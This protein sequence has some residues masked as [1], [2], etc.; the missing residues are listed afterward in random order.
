MDRWPV[1][2]TSPY[3]RRQVEHDADINKDLLIIDPVELLE[4]FS[5]HYMRD[6]GGVIFVSSNTKFE[7]SLP[8]HPL[9]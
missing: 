3:V 4:I 9:L 6:S 7:F 1:I 2:T 8:S 5:L